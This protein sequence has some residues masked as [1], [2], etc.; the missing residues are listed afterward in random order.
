[1]KRIFF[2]LIVMCLSLIG[3]VKT[4]P[5]GVKLVKNY[6]GLRTKSYLCPASVWTVGYGSTEGVTP[7]MTIT[8]KQAEL[9]LIKDLG[10]FEGY[11]D[12]T[13][14][15][16]LIWHEADAL[17]SFT[18]NVGFRLKNE[19]KSAV[20][21]GNAQLVVYKMSLYNKAKVNGQYVILPG[22]VSRR[23]SEGM[24]YKTGKLNF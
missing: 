6:E 13:I 3:Q 22:L 4:T 11:V 23:R 9:M 5:V 15:R 16:L 7:G 17:V 24:L 18:F 10:K 12:R 14:I 20:E 8:E 1:M 21:L 19:L 2:F